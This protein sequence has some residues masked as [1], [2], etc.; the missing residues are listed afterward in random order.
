MKKMNFVK[1]LEKLADVLSYIS[2]GAIALALVNAV[3]LL[4]AHPKQMFTQSSE[5]VGMQNV[6]LLMTNVVI[7]SM[8][9]GIL[10]FYYAMAIWKFQKRNNLYSAE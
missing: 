10:L 8:A 1:K 9:I 7:Y 5:F 4:T 6:E 3:I 2:A